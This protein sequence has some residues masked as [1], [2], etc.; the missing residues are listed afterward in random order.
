MLGVA[1]PE[2]SQGVHHV[3]GAWQME[4][5][6]R[7]TELA[8]SFDG[9]PDQF[10][11][12]FVGPQVATFLQR[13]VGRDEEPHFIYFAVFAKVVGQGQMSDVYG[14]EGTSENADV[15]ELGPL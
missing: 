15:H 4:L 1:L 7:G 5:K 3:A 6:V 2:G 8:V 11:A 14:V 12:Q 10:E 13:V 9:E